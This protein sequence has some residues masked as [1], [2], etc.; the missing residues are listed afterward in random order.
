MTEKNMENTV[1]DFIGAVT[2]KDSFIEVDALVVSESGVRSGEG[3][4]SGFAEIS[5]Q[6][7][8]IFVTDPTVLKGSIGSRNAAK[9]VKC[10]NNAI[11]T[12][13]PIIAVLDTS[14]ARFS[15][16][17]EVMEGYGN[18][19]QAF[20]RAYGLIPTVC[21]VKGNNFGMLSYL[22]ACCDLCISYDKAV[23]A[24]ASPLILAA[25]TKYDAS[26]IGTASIHAQQTGIIGEVVSSDGEL[27]QKLSEYIDLLINKRSD[28]ND[29]PNRVCDSLNANSKAEQIISEVFDKDTF[30]EIRKYY[31]KEFITGFARL[32]G[33]TVGVLASNGA[34]NEGKLSDTAAKKISLLVRTC[35]NFGIPVVSLVD[36]EGVRKNLECE[37]ANLIWELS[38]MIYSLGHSKVCKVALISGNA[39]GLAYVALASKSVFDYT[40]A[41]ENANISMIDND[42]ATTL[43]YA[44][45]IAKGDNLDQKKAITAEFSKKYTEENCRANIVA[46]AGYLDNVIDPVF[47]RQYLIAGVQMFLDKR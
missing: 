38:S 43:V 44:D 20:S 15:E 10:I 26:F 17:I 33:I 47:T 35:D 41:W 7:V 8:G 19:L 27:K 37:N 4:V 12:G 36:S 34:L 2:D 46:R 23:I 22:S 14:G 24:T 9:I 29:D 11:K 18:I 1:Y 28:A 13:S 16:G 40:V 6:K 21:V 25:K 39:I 30:F 32:N 3:V 31:A 5:G 42:A 45:E